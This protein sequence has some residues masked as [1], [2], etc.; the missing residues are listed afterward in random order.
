MLESPLRSRLTG[1]RISRRTLLRGV[2]ALTGGAALAGCGAFGGSERIRLA[3]CSQ[4]LCVVP[5]EVTETAGHFAD[6][7]LEVELI[8]SDGGGAAMQAL[9]GGA[10]DYAATSFDAFA[11]AAEEA[12]G[13]RRFASTGRLPLFALATAPETADE[14]TGI[15]D[16]AGRTIGISS[17]GNA[18]HSILLYLFEQAGIDPDD[19]EF[20]QVGTNAYD[21]VRLG[22]VEAGMV[23]EPALSLLR[24]DGSEVLFNAMDIDDAERFLG[25]AYEFMGVAVREDE[26]EERGEQMR[27][28]GRALAAGLETTRSLS[29][30]EL[31]DALPGELVAGEDTGLL[32]EV[33]EQ[34]QQSLYP[35]S[36]EID[37]PSVQRAIDSLNASGAVE[38]AYEADDLID[39]RILESN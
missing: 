19:V 16:L 25:G 39:L 23:Q 5:Y 7:D 37:P 9:V 3:F 36:V 12:G 21:V 38:R 15:E 26:R 33:L 32:A 18:D 29:G 17:L 35:D 2:G 24:D 20:T 30:R 22:D 14:I 10:V 1:A 4:L 8:Y 13:V 27:R 34:Y 31:I 28:L 11:Q 6:Q